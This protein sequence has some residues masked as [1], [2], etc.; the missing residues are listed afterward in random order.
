LKI[1]NGFVS[2]SS[3]SSFILAWKGN[4]KEELEDAFGFD[5]EYPIQFKGNNFTKKFLEAITPYENGITMQDLHDQYGDDDNDWPNN[6]IIEWMN[7]GYKVG[8][9]D[10]SDDEDDV[11]TFLCNSEIQWDKENLKIIK[12][13]GY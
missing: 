4:L 10:F 9:G 11:E 5:K 3:S 1:R 8:L 2:N 12:E 6:K 7:D 13:M